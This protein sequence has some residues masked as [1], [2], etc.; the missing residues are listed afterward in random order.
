M[1]SRN[2]FLS[3]AA[4]F[5]LTFSIFSAFHYTVDRIRLT[6]LRN[7]VTEIGIAQ[8]HSI[9]MQLN[10]SLS[11]TSAIAI[12]LQQNGEIKNFDLLAEDIISQ[13]GGIS[14]LQLAPDAIVKQIYPLK[15]NEPAIG[16]DLLNDPKRRIE[17][18]KAIESRKLTLAGPFELIQGGT[19][20]IGRYPVYI[21]KGSKPG[22]DKFW[23][24][25]I[26][27]IK[28]S[29]LLKASVI[30]SLVTNA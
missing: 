1:S 25:S 15:G 30:G 12:F 14:N 29:E 11:A 7:A 18:L 4:V 2:K 16:H 5:I 10:H 20:V 9:S 17:V 23:G 6:S 26:V 24:L 3:T 21:D 22:K 19:A 8:A 28:L 27:L 13:Y